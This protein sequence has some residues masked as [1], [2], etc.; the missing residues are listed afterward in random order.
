MQDLLVL[1]Q[2]NDPNVDAAQ[3]PQTPTDGVMGHVQLAVGQVACMG[4]TPLLSIPLYMPES[5]SSGG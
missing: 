2:P 1:L 4:L 5:M 3:A